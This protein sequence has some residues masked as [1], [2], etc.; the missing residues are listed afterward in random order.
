M[1]SLYADLIPPKTPLPNECVIL[2]VFPRETSGYAVLL[3][4]E[5]K[6]TVYSGTISD[7]RVGGVIRDARELAKE[8]KRP[9][10][11]VSERLA[12]GDR[13][14]D[15]RARAMKR[16][17]HSRSWER[18]R[19]EM[20]RLGVPKRRVLATKI[21]WRDLFFAD[22]EPTTEVAAMAV[23]REY[24][25]T[26]VGAGVYINYE[27]AMAVCLATWA[28]HAWDVFWIV[29]YTGKRYP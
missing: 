2:S 22:A 3:S 9:L 20:T 16:L 18:W 25:K 1:V 7:G 17:G 4:S 12:T 13:K 24:G 10:T 23:E 27:E 6:A 26:A 29:R 15:R 14:L 8:H 11:V 5:E 28:R 21:L 19:E